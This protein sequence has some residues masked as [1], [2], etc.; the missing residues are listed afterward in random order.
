MQGQLTLLGDDV[1]FGGETGRRVAFRVW[2]VYD[3]IFWRRVCI[4]FLYLQRPT[5]LVVHQLQ[6]TQFSEW[7]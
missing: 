6:T 7:C 1:T 2:P 4:T 3:A 5:I